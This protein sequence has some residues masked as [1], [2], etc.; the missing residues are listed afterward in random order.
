MM[1]THDSTAPQRA[2]PLHVLIVGAGPC[3]LSCAIATT[4]A[5]HRATVFESV[6]RLHEVGAGLQI[7]PNGSR[8][9]RRWGVD[10]LLRADAAEPDVLRIQR[11]SGELLAQRTDYAQEVQARYGTPLWG[12]H[13]VDLQ[14]AL[15]RRAQQLGATVRLAAKV[16]DV[17]FSVPAVTLADGERVTGDLLVAADGLWSTTR[18]RFLGQDTPPQPTGHMAYRILIPIEEVADSE[19]K[20]WMAKPRNNI[21]IGP[22]A[23]AVAY[24]IRRG[25]LLNIVVLKKDD[26]ADD[27]KK[28]SGD[29]DELRRHLRDWDPM[30]DCRDPF[31]VCSMADS[32]LQIG[33]IPGMCSESR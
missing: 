26:L 7:T 31:T 25:K 23:H 14:T 33:S 9:L 12:L 20:S 8:L 17:D 19:L 3:G 11:F 29:M 1:P 24:S 15:A 4:L 10:A 13:R 21:W 22:E 2:S 6:S 5:G 28:A 16:V 32:S 18:S 27:V 30:Q